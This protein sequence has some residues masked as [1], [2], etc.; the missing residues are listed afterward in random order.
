M[1]TGTQVA[2]LRRH[3]PH[4]YRP[5]RKS[6]ALGFLP[7]G[8]ADEGKRYLAGLT[9]RENTGIVLL[10]PESLPAGT[11]KVF[12]TDLIRVRLCRNLRSDAL[13]L[14]LNDLKL[15]ILLPS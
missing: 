11:V 4:T 2:I 14:S 10:A 12:Q 5:S 15:R 1:D 7:V 6:P 8:G 13:R 9:I 3:K